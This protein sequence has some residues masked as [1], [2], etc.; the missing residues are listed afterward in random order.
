MLRA[1]RIFKFLK[2]LY[3]FINK[4]PNISDDVNRVTSINIT[5]EIEEV[6]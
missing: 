2:L 4:Y 3:Y 6:I 1:D 5:F